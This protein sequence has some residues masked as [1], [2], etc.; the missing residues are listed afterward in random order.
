MEEAAVEEAKAEGERSPAPLD[1]SEAA[2]RLPAEAASP[3]SAAEGFETPK[4]Q[5]VQALL[6]G[7]A[8]PATPLFGSSLAP[9]SP[10]WWGVSEDEE[11]PTPVQGAPAVGEEAKKAA[12]LAR[13]RAAGYNSGGYTAEAC[14]YKSEE[15]AK[16]AVWLARLR[17]AGY[18]SGG[19]TAE[20]CGYKGGAGRKSGGGAPPPSPQR[21]E[22]EEPPS[23]VGSALLVG[24]LALVLVGWRKGAF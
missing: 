15:E 13:L 7:S 19:Y 5:R 16:R 2:L 11:P 18:N 4:P 17:A 6:S 24:V 22:A 10:K 21:D 12:W 8:T 9:I 23:Y 3:G 14:G 20:A 1:V